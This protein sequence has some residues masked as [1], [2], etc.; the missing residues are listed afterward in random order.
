MLNLLSLH[1]MTRILHAQSMSPRVLC[2][3][4]LLR[5]LLADEAALIMHDHSF[6]LLKLQIS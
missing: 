2:Q 3:L 5:N 6:G 4:R 1:I